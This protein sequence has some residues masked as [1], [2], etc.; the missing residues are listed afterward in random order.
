MSNEELAYDFSPMLKVYKDGRVERLI[1]TDIA[2][3][4]TDPKTGVQSKDVVNL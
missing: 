4:S 1:G 2:P 3:P